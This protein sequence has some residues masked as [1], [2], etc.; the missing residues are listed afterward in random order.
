M[1]MT[2][3]ITIA[4]LL[5]FWK[6]AVSIIL[7][8]SMATVVPSFRKMARSDVNVNHE[9]LIAVAQNNL[10][11]LKKTIIERGTPGHK[12]YQQWLSF[13]EIGNL[14]KNDAAYASIIT[15]L[16][17]SNVSVTWSSP[18]L[19]YIRAT[20]TIGVWEVVLNTTFFEW[21]LNKPP[22]PNVL[23]HRSLQYYVPKHLNQHVFA[24]FNTCQAPQ[25]LTHFSRILTPSV[26]RES[27]LAHLTS[28]EVDVPF[29][30]SLYKITDSIGN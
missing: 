30:N 19:D 23:Y 27:K 18:R 7:K 21:E 25:T 24:I 16:Q 20:A 3:S 2:K 13:D 14:T 6:C 22:H 17:S 9:V 26:D 4:I 28:V 8:E 1:V 11:Y 12:L 10:D 29:L 15:W 5:V